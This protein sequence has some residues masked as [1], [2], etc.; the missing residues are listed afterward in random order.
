MTAWV[1]A[2]KN[3]EIGIG[4]THSLRSKMEVMVFVIYMAPAKLSISDGDV[5]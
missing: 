4:K 3:L 2:G 1:S 5:C